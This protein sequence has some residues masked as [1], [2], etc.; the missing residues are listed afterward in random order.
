M[1][2]LERKSELGLAIIWM[3]VI[4]IISNKMNNIPQLTC[5]LAYSFLKTTY[6]SRLTVAEMTY[7]DKSV[8]K[9]WKTRQLKHI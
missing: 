4:P 2:E 6:G 5:Y 1:V 9:I 8:E 3:S 7:I